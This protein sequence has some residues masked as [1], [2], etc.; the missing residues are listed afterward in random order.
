MP[1]VVRSCEM[2]AKPSKEDSKWQMMLGVVFCQIKDLGI[3][4]HIGHVLRFEH[5]NQTHATHL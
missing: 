1:E 2:K 4:T 5:G 3:A